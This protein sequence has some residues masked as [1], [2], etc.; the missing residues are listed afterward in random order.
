M[1][2]DY[3]IADA[4]TVQEIETELALANPSSVYADI[5]RKALGRRTVRALTITPY[6]SRLKIAHKR[7]R[8][9]K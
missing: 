8:G 6:G 2:K 9:N 1:K 3:E 7:M 4:L 5:C